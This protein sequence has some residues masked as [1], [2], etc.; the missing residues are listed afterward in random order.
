MDAVWGLGVRSGAPLERPR[1]TLT[2]Y[3]HFQNEGQKNQETNEGNARGG[4]KLILADSCS[5]RDRLFI[6]IT[7]TMTNAQRSEVLRDGRPLRPGRALLQRLETMF[8]SLAP[9]GSETSVG[10]TPLRCVRHGKIK[11]MRNL[12]QVHPPDPRSP[13][14]SHPIRGRGMG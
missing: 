9:T 12:P 4:P 14:A 2:P 5:Q 13:Q 3:F 6:A 1:P 10:R 8:A 11:S 7:I